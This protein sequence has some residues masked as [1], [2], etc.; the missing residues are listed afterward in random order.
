MKTLITFCTVIIFSAFSVAFAQKADNK[1]KDPATTVIKPAVK[2][3]QPP[4]AEQAGNKKSESGDVNSSIMNPSTAKPNEVKPSAI[5][6]SAVKASTV[7]KTNNPNN[8]QDLAAPVRLG[9]H[10]PYSNDPDYDAKKAEWMK[11]YPEEYAPANNPK[12]ENK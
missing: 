12:T 1:T 9:E 4:S 6:A 5:N 3:D 10:G 11:N 8:I 2:A 7:Q